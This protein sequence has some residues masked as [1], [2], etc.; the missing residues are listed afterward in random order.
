MRTFA[1]TFAYQ[2][3]GWKMTKTR[4]TLKEVAIDAGVSY[5]T[6][7]KVINKQVRISPETEERIW[8]AIR[9]LGYH[10]NYTARSLRY[11]RAFTIG[12][13]WPLSSRDQPNPIHDQFLQ[14]MLQAAEKLG[15]YLL[16][17]PYHT[18]LTNRLATYSEL[19]NSGRVDGFV[20]SGIEYN[21][22]RVQL[23]QKEGFPFVGFGRSNPDIDF[24]WI[25]VNGDHGIEQAVNHLLELGHRRI[26]ALA[27]PESS[28]VGNNRMEGYMTALRMA[29]ITPDPRWIA[30][31]EGKYATGYQ[32]TSDLLDLPQDIRPTALI[33]LNDAM[34]VGALWA[35]KNRGLLV[36]Q[37]FSITG[38]DDVPMVQY[39]DPP[40]TS[41]RQPV[42][43]VGEQIIPLL[44]DFINNG[45]SMETM[46]ILVEPTLIVRSSTGI[47][48]SSTR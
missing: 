45:F 43:E 24:P 20:L 48:K 27:W 1:R 38:F 31:G 11:Q 5:Q 35:V 10:P 2:P 12:Y 13:S 8:D 6:V 33:A 19:I 7:S 30:R 29:G 47:C 21:D 28:R 37:D 32:K 34:A 16:T 17:F 44:L 39:L 18:D 46:E 26:A 36:G 9:K 3:D 42:W 40:L 15:Y 14:S 41:V 25:D 23:L 22:P 4:V